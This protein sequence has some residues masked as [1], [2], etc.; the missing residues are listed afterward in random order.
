MS[1]DAGERPVSDTEVGAC[2]KFKP[3]P[4]SPLVCDIC[5]KSLGSH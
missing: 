4:E 1:A 5:G 3:K 2:S